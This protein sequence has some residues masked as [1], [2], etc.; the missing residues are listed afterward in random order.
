MI[1][2]MFG[3]FITLAMDQIINHAAKFRYMYNDQV[4]VPLI[5][6][7][8][9]GGRRGYGPTHSQTLDRHLFGIP[10]LRMIAINNLIHP[11]IIYQAIVNFSEDPTIIIENKILYTL[12]L[13][14]VPPKGFFYRKI[15]THYPIIIVEPESHEVDVCIIAYG[16]LSNL[17]VDIVVEL[18]L[19]FDIVARFI[20]PI[21]I[22]PF[23][24]NS[25]LDHIKKCKALVIV[26]EGQ[27]FAAFGAEIMAQLYSLN[28]QF[29]IKATRVYATE[30]PIPASKT[31]E[32][33]ALPGKEKIM[34]TILKL[35][36]AEHT[37]SH[38]PEDAYV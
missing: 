37:A 5:I 6:R 1:E 23:A 18:F 2:I 26:E 17:I 31:L 24:I 38:L 8:P 35:L 32:N 34:Q 14:E 9:M 22:Y 29:L 30:S 4:R 27:G 19:E 12:P 3:D 15:G 20:C 36:A 33:Q 13:R 10:G 25:C 11:K 28:N 21:Q 16:G 7:T